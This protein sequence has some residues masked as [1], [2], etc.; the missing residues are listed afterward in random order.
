MRFAEAIRVNNNAVRPVF[1]APNRNEIPLFQ[2]AD[3][4]HRNLSAFINRYAIHTA[5]L[6]EP[7]SAPDFEIFWEDAHG[8]VSFRCNGIGRRRKPNGLRCSRKFFFGKIRR[9][10]SA[11][12]KV[13]R[14]HPSFFA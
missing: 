6:C 9:Y 11:Q 3:F 4:A 13:H 7:P 12:R 14:C 8:M 1:R 2:Q 5:F 10:V